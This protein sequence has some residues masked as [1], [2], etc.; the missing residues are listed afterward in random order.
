MI[1]CLGASLS[2][3]GDKM[4]LWAKVRKKSPTHFLDIIR[5]KG[6]FVD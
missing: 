4:S 5:R 3:A 2:M 1:M 6:G